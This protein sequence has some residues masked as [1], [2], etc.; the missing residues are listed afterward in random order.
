MIIPAWQNRQPRVQPRNTSTLR[1]SCTTSISGTSCCFG[2][3]HCALVD[4]RGHIGK[5]RPDLADRRAVVDH[6][7]ERW[8]VGTGHPGQLPQDRLPATAAAV[9]LPGPDDLGHLAHDLLALTDHEDVDKVAQ[10]FGVE[11][12]VATG[13]D[14]WVFR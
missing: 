6:V 13:H 3:G 12:T 5:L 10:R 7:V 1:R 9:A 11:R 2:Y 14:Q 4:G 8:H